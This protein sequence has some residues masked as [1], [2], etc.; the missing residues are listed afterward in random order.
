MVKDDAQGIGTLTY[1]DQSE[2]FGALGHGITD[3]STGTI[4]NISGGQIYKTH[5][6]SI[7]KGKDGTP[8]ELQGIIDYKTPSQSEV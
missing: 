4:M 6:L 2:H 3:N 8:G 1:I 5:I 7:I